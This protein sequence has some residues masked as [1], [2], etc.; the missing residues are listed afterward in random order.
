VIMRNALFS[1]EMPLRNLVCSLKAVGGTLATIAEWALGRIGF[2]LL[3]VFRE[4]WIISLFILVRA[5]GDQALKSARL[6]SSLVA[7]KS[8][9]VYKSWLI[10]PSFFIMAR[11][12]L[13]AF[14]F[15]HL[16]SFYF[17][18]SARG[19]RVKGKSTMSLDFVARVILLGT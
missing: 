5:A 11:I 10:D 16:D 19:G 15:P 1:V 9:R 12:E 13:R 4:G 3:V 7:S 18:P 8:S 17:L 14:G 2:F 6:E